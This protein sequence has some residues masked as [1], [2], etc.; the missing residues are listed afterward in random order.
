MGNRWRPPD[1]QTSRLPENP[2]GLQER[3]REP[4]GDEQIGGLDEDQRAEERGDQG[5]GGYGW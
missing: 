4:R 1:G 5:S 2:G 3:G